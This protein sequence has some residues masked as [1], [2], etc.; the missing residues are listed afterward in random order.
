[1]V[2]YQIYLLEGAII[3]K[4]L[5]LIL[6]STLTLVGCAS[7]PPLVETVIKKHDF[8]QLDTI[9]TAEL[10]DTMVLHLYSAT[11]PSYKLLKSWS[12]TAYGGHVLAAGHV[13][14]PRYEDQ[15]YEG[16]FE[17]GLCR[18]KE[19]GEWCIGQ[20]AFGTC[21]ALTCGVNIT[22]PKEGDLNVERADY[23]DV[24]LPNLRQ[25]LIYNGK[26]GNSVKF[27]YRELSQNMMRDAFS[28]DIQYDLSEGN[29]IGFKGVR[30]RIIEATNRKI[31]YKVSAH[32]IQ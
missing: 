13:L 23:V 4:Y 30:L 24:T 20:N 31:E 17:L 14:R 3:K 11:S 18:V 6:L 9:A 25:E 32:F 21:N 19:S 29:E 5:F 26:V 8:P 12:T 27:L 22:G 7:A 2:I 16:F 28:Q 10:G 15:K 1:M